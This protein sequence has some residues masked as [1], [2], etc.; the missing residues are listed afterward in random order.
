MKESIESGSVSSFDF[1]SLINQ[2]KIQRS[3]ADRLEEVARNA[4]HRDP[5]S[6]TT[7]SAI[8]ECEAAID[9]AAQLQKRL[10]TETRAMLRAMRKV[11]LQ[12]LTIS[13]FQ[14]IRRELQDESAQP[15]ADRLVATVE[16]LLAG[17]RLYK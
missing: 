6:Q 1:D 12:A 14:K 8:V 17:I 5:D 16:L 11:K 3:E 13:E 9:R 7:V 10:L 2:L 15:D 4:M